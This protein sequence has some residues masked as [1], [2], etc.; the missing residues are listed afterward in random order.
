MAAKIVALPPWLNTTSTSDLG[1]ETQVWLQ[2]HS[3]MLHASWQ[4][5]CCQ[6]TR[7]CLVS[8]S[9]SRN[10]YCPSFR[11]WSQ[12]H[13]FS[14]L[15]YLTDGRV[16][17]RRV[18]RASRLSK[19]YEAEARKRLQAHSSV[20]CKNK[21]PSGARPCTWHALQVGPKVRDVMY[22]VANT[23]TRLEFNSELRVVHAPN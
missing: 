9:L 3:S 19:E 12:Q 8:L 16:R 15:L 14:E 13:F 10:P 11:C 23:Q 20:F 21:T 6:F 2:V 1:S 22:S 7:R 18:R 4:A 17:R 5:C